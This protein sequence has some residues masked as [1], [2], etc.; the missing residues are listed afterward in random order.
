MA[1]ASAKFGVTEFTAMIIETEDCQFILL[2]SKPL[3]VRTKA[4]LV[5]HEV[6]AQAR[7]HESF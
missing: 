7:K 3:E 5:G 2:A 6:N 4:F 1:N